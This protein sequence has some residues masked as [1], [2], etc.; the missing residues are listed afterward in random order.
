MF[1]L[2]NK[3]VTENKIL[4][5]VCS[6]LDLLFFPVIGVC[7][8][9]PSHSTPYNMNIYRTLNIH[10]NFSPPNL[11]MS[12]GTTFTFRIIHVLA[13]RKQII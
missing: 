3:Y 11:K 10:L 2:R 7:G 1:W 4:F 9:G 6:T 8:S 12:F 13:F 5:F